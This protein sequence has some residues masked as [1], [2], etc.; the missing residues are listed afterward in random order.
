M[1][2]NVRYF[3]ELKKATSKKEESIDVKVP[4]VE[5][6]LKTLVSKYGEEV[7]KMIVDEKT[8]VIGTRVKVLVNGRDIR[9]L[10]FL[11]T[12]LA[13]GDTVSVMPALR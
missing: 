8:K 10:E 13:E 5:S 2:V 11:D 6:L 7:A 3:L 4:T 1:K 9:F 12:Q